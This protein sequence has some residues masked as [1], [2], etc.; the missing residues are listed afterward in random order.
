MTSLIISI[1]CPEITEDLQIEQRSKV[2]SNWSSKMEQ[3]DHACYWKEKI[4][5]KDG[6]AQ[7]E[8]IR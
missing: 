8:S 7:F 6:F 1:V 4:L 2:Q 5:V 3:F